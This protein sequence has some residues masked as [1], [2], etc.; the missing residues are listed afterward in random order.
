[1]DRVATRKKPDRTPAM[2][3]NGLKP[4]VKLPAEK[5]RF[6]VVDDDA[7]MLIIV[8][9]TLL[10][11]GASQVWQADTGK[12]GQQLWDE[13]NHEIDVLIADIG[14][15]DTSG[16][17]FARDLKAARPSLHALLISGLPL[18]GFVSQDIPLLRKPFT[19]GQLI[20]ALIS[21]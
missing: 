9:K 20:N 11:G 16:L 21:L 10:L 8:K 3:E 15:P 7:N 14:L 4:E 17:Q 6:L 1:V 2:S 13:H 18:P 19:A 12:D 5:R